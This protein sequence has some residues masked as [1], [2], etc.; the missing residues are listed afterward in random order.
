M[1]PEFIHLH[2]HSAFSLLDGCTKVEKLVKWA[3]EQKMPAIAVTDTGNVFG[4]MALAHAGCDNGVQPILGCQLLVKSP[5]KEVVLGAEPTFDSVV[6]LVQS[7]EGYHSLLKWFTAYYMASEKQSQPH[8]T[9]EELCT[10]TNGLILLTGG[11][12]GILGRPLLKGDVEFARTLLKKMQQ[13][14]PNRVY[15]EIMRHGEEAEE[16]TEPG[17]LQLAYD[18]NVPLVATNE[19]FFTN[20]DL[21]E[22]HDALMCIADKT[23]VAESDRRKV[24]NQYYLKTADEMKELFKDLPEALE[25]TVRIAQRCHFMAEDKKPAFPIFVVGAMALPAVAL[26]FATANLASASA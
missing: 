18:E 23:Y 16:L 6:V 8:L 24:N 1:T 20:P 10:N 7:E 21:Y 14:F 22:A 4:A 13:A 5:E 19:C 11:A 3:A 12:K 2:V 26:P 9:F 25:N 17:F 15:M